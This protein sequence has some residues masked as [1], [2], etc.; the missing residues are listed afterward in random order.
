MTDVYT[1]YLNFL[2]ANKISDSVLKKA[3]HKDVCNQII[4]ILKDQ[5]PKNILEIGTFKGF[6]MGLFRYFMP[7]CNVL[8]IDIVRHKE[9]EQISLLF[10]NCKLIKGDSSHIYKQNIQTKFDFILIDGDHSYNS[11]KKD[12]NNVQPNIS[13]SCTILFD[14][15]GHLR[16]CGKVFYEIK[17]DRY[18]KQT[19]SHDG[20][21]CTGILKK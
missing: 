2:I 7:N 3:L 17:D 16:G 18:S 13:N 4:P 10:G 5:S 21:E 20:I 15:L 19:I 14:D 12:W 11:C 1:E 6:S 8:S 9:A